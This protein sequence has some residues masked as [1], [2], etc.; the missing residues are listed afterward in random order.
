MPA[1]RSRYDAYNTKPN[2]KQAESAEAR[3]RLVRRAESCICCDHPKYFSPPHDA[4]RLHDY[5]TAP[6]KLIPN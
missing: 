4:A 2:N 1:K 3:D 5:R 6:W